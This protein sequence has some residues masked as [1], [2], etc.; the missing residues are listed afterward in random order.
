[1]PAG[2]GQECW[3]CYWTGLAEARVQMDCAAFS[4]PALAEHFQSFGTWL[5]QRVRGHK[6]ALTIH[7]Y[8]E[9]FLEVQHQWQD[10]PKYETLL[11]HFSAV[12]LRR[13]LLPLRWMEASG[14]VTPNA[15]VREADSDQ[16]RI[17]ASLDKFPEQSRERTILNGYYEYL[18]Q[19]VEK[20]ATTLRS[21]RLAISRRHLCWHLLT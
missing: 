12:G 11:R 2:C 20:S 7:N 14:L 1:M 19:R 3:T 4:S 5:I 17:Q 21:V 16:R 18:M 15:T 6:A 13:Y 10:I 9:F 8:L